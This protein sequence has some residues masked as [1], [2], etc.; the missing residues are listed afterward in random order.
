MHIDPLKD[1]DILICKATD[2]VDPEDPNTK[3]VPITEGAPHFADNCP[4]W[5]Y[6]LAEA[7]HHKTKVEAPVTE[8]TKITTPQLGPVG[9]R[10]V[11]E[12]FLGMLFGD[13][14][15]LLSLDPQWV[16]VSGSDFRLKDIVLYALGQG[17]A[18][19]YPNG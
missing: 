12:V 15:S 13:G 5:V 4:L 7:A 2:K 17:F 19:S 3:R 9:G 11:A 10:I 18:L 6:I 1:K 16:P 14:S 8:K